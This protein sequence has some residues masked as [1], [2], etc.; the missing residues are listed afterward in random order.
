MLVRVDGDGGIGLVTD[1]R[2]GLAGQFVAPVRTNPA[3]WQKAVCRFYH[4]Q[5]TVNKFEGKMPL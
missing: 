3:P 4:T 5:G 1:T 2:L